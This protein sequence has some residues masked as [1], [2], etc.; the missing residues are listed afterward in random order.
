MAEASCEKGEQSLHR[1]GLT[2]ED[3]IAEM[4]ESKTTPA[5]PGK[6]QGKNYLFDNPELHPEKFEA[7][8]L[9]KRKS[10][11]LVVFRK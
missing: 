6:N 3:I 1:A 7:N 8:F 10:L 9:K 2:G 5:V 4:V 11:I